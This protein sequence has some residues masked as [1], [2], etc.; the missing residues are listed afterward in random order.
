MTQNVCVHDHTH[1]VIQTKQTRSTLVQNYYL[2]VDSV[3][4]IKCHKSM[5]HQ[6]KECKGTHYC[7]THLQ[8]V[9]KVCNKLLKDEMYP[10][11]FMVYDQ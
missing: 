6:K 1:S 9:S 10:I 5:E 4:F 11:F 8:L 7:R 2:L 3:I